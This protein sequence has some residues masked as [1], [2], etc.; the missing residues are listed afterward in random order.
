MKTYNKKGFLSPS[1]ISSMSAFHAKVKKDGECQ[2]RLHDCNGG[3][4]L[5]GN[6]NNPEERLEMIEKLGTLECAVR[7]LRQWI[8][9]CCEF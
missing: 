4:R 1:S 5:I 3:V 6:L 9:G 7:D 2:F 8:V